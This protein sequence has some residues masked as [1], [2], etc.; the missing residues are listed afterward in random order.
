MFV[1]I[2]EAESIKEEASFEEAESINKE[3]ETETDGVDGE[4]KD[5][6]RRS[7]GPESTTPEVEVGEWRDE[8]IRLASDT[9]YRIHV[10]FKVETKVQHMRMLYRTSGIELSRQFV[11]LKKSLTRKGQYTTNFPVQWTKKDRDWVK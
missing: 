3:E 6:E 9:F 10:W 7:V 1:L 2:K 11:H 5:E 4:W 8:E